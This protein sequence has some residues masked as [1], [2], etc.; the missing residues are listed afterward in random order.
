[1]KHTLKSI[2]AQQKRIARNVSKLHPDNHITR[3]MQRKYR[4]LDNLKTRL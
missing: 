2:E 1:M 3:E 4:E